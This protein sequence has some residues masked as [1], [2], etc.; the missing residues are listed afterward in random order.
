MKQLDLL[1]SFITASNELSEVALSD[2]KKSVFL[3]GTDIN[4]KNFDAVFIELCTQNNMF[5]AGKSFFQMLQNQNRLNLASIGKFLRLCFALRDSCSEEDKLLIKLLCCDLTEKYPV[6]DVGTYES[7]ILGISVTD[8]WKESMNILQK[9]K[10]VGSPISRV[11][12]AIAEAAFSNRDFELGWAILDE[13]L[14]MNKEPD[15]SVYKK[16]LCT[17]KDDNALNRLLSFISTHN[18]VITQEL[19]DLIVDNYQRLKSSPASITKIS[20]T[21]ICNNCT[22]SLQP[23]DVTPEE[24]MLLKDS[25]LKPVLIGNDVYLKSKPGEIDAYLKFLTNAGRVDVVLDGLNIAYAAGIKKSSPKVHSK[26]LMDVVKYFVAR[27]MRV[28]VIGRKHMVTWPKKNMD[29]IFKSSSTF[30]ADNVSSDDPL[31]LFGAMYSGLGTIFVSRDLMKSHKFLI[32]ESNIRQIF[33]RWQQK[34]QYYLK[35]V[36]ISGNVTFQVIIFV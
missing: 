16:W 7:I 28:M 15:I 3:L 17:N 10:E 9:A 35:H 19:S 20:S 30:L 4:E 29:F 18:I 5:T 23:V 24:F 33:E 11:Y 1:T 2:L 6:L 21:G 25:F 36:D 8:S 14:Q 34:H 27:N 12:S 32:K 31:L 13:L 26:M 22:K